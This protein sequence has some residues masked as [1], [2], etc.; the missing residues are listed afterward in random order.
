MG[1]AVG[2]VDGVDRE[3]STFMAEG[4]PSTPA[5]TTAVTLWN[6]LYHLKRSIKECE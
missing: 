5:P 1:K 6:A 3:D 2:G 4:R